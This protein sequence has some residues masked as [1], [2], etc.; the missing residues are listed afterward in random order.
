MTY[1]IGIIGVGFVGGAIYQSFME[2][3]IQVVAYD[4]YKNI[5]SFEDCLDTDMIFLALPTLFDYETD[6]YDLEAL[7]NVCERLNTAQYKN[8]IVIK[9]TISPLTTE[10]LS[11]KY[12]N[13]QFCHNP[14]F[15]KASTAYHDFHNQS[16]IVLGRGQ[17]CSNNNY[18]MLIDF[19]K[20]YW[21]DATISSCTS[22]ES[23]SMKIFI[24]SFYASKIQLF[25]EYYLLCNKL[26]ID[27]ETVRLL[28]LKNNRIN[29]SDTMVP[30]P[31]G[32]LGYGGACFPKD[33]NALLST[34]KKAESEYKVLE[35][36]IQERNLV[37]PDD[38]ETKLYNE[39]NEKLNAKH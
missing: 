5:N 36:V 29:P 25:N 31:D 18:M 1:K 21:P 37:R 35:S 16:H 20:T 32:E 28:M 27:F 33:T 30:G 7:I 22:D 6:K 38:P 17:N 19:Y 13:L 26:N 39:G 3:N 4:K 10:M 24:N 9:S 34:M 12:Q 15:L 14:E 23:E 8:L 2:K 11:N